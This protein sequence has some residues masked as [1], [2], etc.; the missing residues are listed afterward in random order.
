VIRAALR[1]RARNG[2]STKGAANAAPRHLGCTR[3]VSRH[4]SC[5]RFYASMYR[6]DF[7]SRRG[8]SAKKFR[9]IGPLAGRR[10]Q[11]GRCQVNELSPAF[12]PSVPDFG[13]GRATPIRLTGRQRTASVDPTQRLTVCGR[14]GRPAEHVG[15]FGVRPDEKRLFTLLSVKR[16]TQFLRFG[17]PQIRDWR[18]ER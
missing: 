5:S 2:R 3:G 4:G 9:R 7:A 8:D 1:R 15:M 11:A 6:C 13:G 16:W 18:R 14:K 12:F 10:N 17:S